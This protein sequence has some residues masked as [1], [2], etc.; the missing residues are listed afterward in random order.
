MTEDSY[1]D[2][3]WFGFNDIEMKVEA[4]TEGY[5]TILQA[6]HDGWVAYVDGEETE[7]SIVNQCFMGIHV[8]PGEHDI[9]MKFRPKEFFVGMSIT[10]I[11]IITMIVVW[12]KTIYFNYKKTN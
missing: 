8:M 4:P 11:Y 7:I 10:V 9:V 2:V 6:M 5:V 3:S 1:V 12:L